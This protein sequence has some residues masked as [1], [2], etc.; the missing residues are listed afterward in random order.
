MVVID[1][2]FVFWDGVLD[3]THKSICFRFL[4]QYTPQH[5]SESVVYT[6]HRVGCILSV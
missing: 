2:F 5:V 4:L 1:I 3:D 6:G